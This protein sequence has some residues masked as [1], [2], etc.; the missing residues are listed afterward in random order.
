M[1]KASILIVD[2]D[3]DILY[4]FRVLLEE[5]GYTVSTATTGEEALK[6]AEKNRYELVLLDYKLTDT[7]GEIIADKLKK[8]DESV[9]IIYITGYSMKN[10]EIPTNEAVKEIL[11]KP[12]PEYLL[13]RVVSEA[14]ADQG[15]QTEYEG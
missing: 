5:N 13:L 9:Q 14:V 8:M 7:S 3:E 1:S 15:V 4:F 10:G 2:D 11:V 6:K 12:I